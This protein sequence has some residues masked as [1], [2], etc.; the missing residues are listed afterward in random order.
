M[1][2]IQVNI[3]LIRTAVND[4]EA[5]FCARFVSMQFDIRLMRTAFIDMEF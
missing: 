2:L 3:R 5:Q 1:E 4:L